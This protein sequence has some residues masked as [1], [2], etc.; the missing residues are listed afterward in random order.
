[1]FWETFNNLCSLKNEK[2]TPVIKKLGISTSMATKWK[3]GSVPNGKTLKVIADYFG[4]STDYLLGNT[5]ERERA[6]ADAELSAE[7]KELVDLFNRVP[8][9]QKELV[10]SLL[11]SLEQ[12][13]TQ[14]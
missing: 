4:V 3:N 12:K 14:D 2:P 1:M 5:D 6:G 11:R 8:D 13:G 7:E 9:A 10:L